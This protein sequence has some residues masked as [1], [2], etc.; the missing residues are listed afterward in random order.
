MSDV[1]ESLRVTLAQ[2]GFSIYE[3]RTS[4]A[5]PQTTRENEFW[6]LVRHW[7]LSIVFLAG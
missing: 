4:A 2:S 1:G 5:P 7:E 6:G 3:A